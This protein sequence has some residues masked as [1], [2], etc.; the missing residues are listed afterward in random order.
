MSG[1]YQSVESMTGMTLLD[2]VARTYNICCDLID[3]YTMGGIL[4]IQ[5]ALYLLPC[6]SGSRGSKNKYNYLGYRSCL[7]FV[8]Q[9]IFFVL[10][11]HGITRSHCSGGR[12]CRL[13]LKLKF[14]TFVDLTPIGP[15]LLP[16]LRVA[17]PDVIPHT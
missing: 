15:D 11:F 6:L 1:T 10:L 12:N 13:D 4:G 9:H 3:P 16:V 2:E 5:R 14:R 17:G 7:L 8:R